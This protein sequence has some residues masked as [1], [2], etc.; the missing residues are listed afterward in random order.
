MFVTGSSGLSTISWD[1]FFNSLSRYYY[2]LRQ[3][4]PPLQD[5]VYRQRVHPK[6]ITPNEIQGL[7]AVLQ[8]VQVIASNDELSRIAFCE[9]PGWKVLQSLVG[10]V[11]CA[12]PNPLKGVLVRTLAALA[13][14]PESSCSIWQNIEAAQL[15]TTVPT[16][17]SYR[18]R[19]VQTELE[20]VESRNEEYP[21]TCA[22]LNLLDVLTDFP[23]PRLL[24]LGRRNPGFD[25]YLNFV[26]NDVLL[27]F[28]TRS[29][30]NPAEKWQLASTCLH[31]L[32]KLVRQYEPVPEDFLGCRLE[33]QAEEISPLN[34]PPGY[35]I[36]SQLHSNSEL[37]RTLLRILDEGCILFDTYDT[38]SGKSDL[39][40]ATLNC[41]ELIEFGLRSQHQYMAQLTTVPSSAL[42]HL[43]TKLSSM[44]IP[45]EAQATV[46]AAPIVSFN[47]S[48]SRP[49]LAGLSR[50]LLGVNLRSGKPD[51]M[52]NV[53]KYILYASW[54]QQHARVAVGIIEIVANEPGADA[55]LLATF[56]AT[57]SLAANIRHGFAECL[58]TFEDNMINSI[59]NYDMTT[60]SK[61]MV[62][63][64][65]SSTRCEQHC[66]NKILQLLMQS[67]NKPSP[68]L[69]HY[70][71]GFDITRDIR[72]TVIQQPGIHSYPR[73]CLHSIV[74][75]L[76][77]SLN[78]KI[79]DKTTEACYCFLHNLLSNNK[80]S[81]PVLRFLRTAT[82]QDFI[83]RHL[84]KLP[85]QGPNQDSDLICMAWLL[86]IT[87]IELRVG[88]GSLQ[89]ALIQR[90]VGKF[91]FLLTF[92]LL[93]K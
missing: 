70:L 30:R 63:T 37:L 29:Y 59:N 58:D 81:M 31:I 82:N 14:S 72:N 75:L 67:I 93:Y 83:Q 54:L 65:F 56:T 27:R 41:L 13:K 20:E 6:G 78:D 2:N 7:E 24:G 53:A 26:V 60:T 91:F 39:E 46:L 49:L 44:T 9:H 80:T 73:T 8:V 55:E 66:K 42:Q 11:S 85:F 74:G 34:S 62:T 15:I 40:V 57:P 3:E 1:H 64:E 71:L 12:M 28:D 18:I 16:T 36:L 47:G 43:P 87:A 88:C 77:L 22:V 19:G 25:P 76:E 50:L 38:F 52:V 68:N 45:T 32:L 17:S 33:L 89:N 5:T 84:A 86:K 10:L 51:H 23:V 69:A 90:L 4:L 79:R 92:I 35:H 61:P 48:N 21:L